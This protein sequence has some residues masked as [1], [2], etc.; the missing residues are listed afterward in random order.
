M[1]WVIAGEPQLLTAAIAANPALLSVSFGDD[2]SWVPRAHDA[3]TAA[4][5]QVGDLAG[6]C[7]RRPGPDA[8]S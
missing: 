1:E 7:A 6:R 4:A 3:G 2:F 8:T 5:T